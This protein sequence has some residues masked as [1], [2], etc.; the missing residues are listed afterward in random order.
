MQ[1]GELDARPDPP[2]S[3]R[4]RIVG[5]LMLMSFVNY[6]NRISMPVAGDRIMREYPID[7]VRMGL[8]YSALLVA[9]TAFM[10]PGGW[11]S[12]RVGGRVALATVGLG[13]AAFCV[14]SGL[15]GHPAL[16]VGMV[17]P[18]LLV[19]R[20]F[21]GMFTSPLYPAAGRVVTRW[22]PFRGRALANAL[23]MTAAM[24]GIALAHP[25]F[26]RLMDAVGWRQAFA[27]SGLGT[28]LLA[29]LW[30][31]YGR[32]DPGR[33]PSVNRAERR[34]IGGGGPGGPVGPSAGRLADPSPAAVAS[35][36]A[37]ADGWPALSRNRS[38]W[39]LTACYAAIGYSEYLVFYWSGHYFEQV[40]QLGERTSRIAAMLPPLAM[41]V[42]L[43]LGGWVADRLMGPLGYR[44][45]RA[46]VAMGGMVGCGL[47]LCAGTLT[48]SPAA[49]VASFALALGA[50]GICEGAS[51]ATAI[52]LGGSRAATSAAIVNTGGN[53]GGFLSPV[54]TPWIGA[55]LTPDLGRELGWAWGLRIGG[56]V[57]LAGACLWPWI[58]AGER[59]RNRPRGDGAPAGPPPTGGDRPVEPCVRAEP[60][61]QSNCT[62]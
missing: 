21:M 20:A 41:G 28:A 10:V 13:T 54:V 58:D 14:L 5:L 52:D 44:W 45:A 9:Y 29:A 23:V 40:L 60:Q 8:V 50:I 22:I 43:P 4:W 6:F 55:L 3:V 47:L 61:Q 18:T 57:C 25:L 19:V 38:L 1:P 62:S 35:A 27:V 42:G 26:A 46:S 15:A 24:L 17:W 53:V 34:L 31:W 36:S 16:A 37:P 33:H 11:F 7:E 30:I 32:D 39:L 51:W 12:D 59:G 49:I 2:T 56:L 48:A